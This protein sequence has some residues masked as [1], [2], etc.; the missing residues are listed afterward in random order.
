MLSYGCRISILDYQLNAYRKAGISDVY[1]IVGYEGDKIKTHCKYI[2]D[3]NITI[4][5]N[6]EYE[7]TN[8][9]YSLFLVKKYVYNKSFILNNADLAIS[10]RY[11]K[12]HG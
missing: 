11:N 7:I 1:I 8:N 12:T 5:E 6:D 9:M 4:I 3:L 10:G 2:K